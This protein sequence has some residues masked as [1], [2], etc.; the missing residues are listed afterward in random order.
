[1]LC[2]SHFAKEHARF[3]PSRIVFVMIQ[4]MQYIPVY[5]V[6]GLMSIIYQL[7]IKIFKIHFSIFIINPKSKFSGYT[8]YTSYMMS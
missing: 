6:F 2:A 8:Q 1:M 5:D 3:H 7:L 4:I